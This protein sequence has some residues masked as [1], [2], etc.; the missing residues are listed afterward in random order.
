MYQQPPPPQK[1]G[2]KIAGVMYILGSVFQL[3][4]LLFGLIVATAGSIMSAA[5]DDYQSFATY[6]WAVCVILPLTGMIFGFLGGVFALMGRN[7]MISLV[8]G[9]PGM[10]AGI[11]SGIIVYGGKMACNWIGLLAFIFF[12]IGVIMVFMAKKN[13]K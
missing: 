7:F 3:S 5:I 11:A 6:L 9:I 12:L 2:S 4:T 8:G 1:S 10:V 13:F